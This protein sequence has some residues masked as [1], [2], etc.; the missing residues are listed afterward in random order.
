MLLAFHNYE[1]TFGHLPPA[2]IREEYGSPLLSWRVAVLPYVEGDDLYRAMHLDESWESPHNLSLLA[3]CPS[4]YKSVGEQPPDPNMTF[5]R[6]FTGPG[7]AFER[8][9]LKLSDMFDGTSNVIGIIEAGEAVPWTKPEELEYAPDKPL[10]PLGGIFRSSTW[11]DR[12][13]DKWDGFQAAM[14]DGS[15]QRFPRGFDEA[16]LRAL[17]VRNSGLDKKLD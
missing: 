2:A 5:Y 11:L 15:V 7:T 16:K 9:G 4:L 13:R 12:Q 6:V 17:I 1:S 14:M 8:D 10:P 3:Q